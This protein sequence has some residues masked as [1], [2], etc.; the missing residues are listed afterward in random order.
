[1]P[2]AAMN[3]KQRL[4]EGGLRQRCHSPFPWR[5]LWLAAEDDHLALMVAADCVLQFALLVV[6]RQ[7]KFPQLQNILG[8]GSP[9]LEELCS[10]MKSCSLWDNGRVHV[11]R[12]KAQFADAD[13]ISIKGEHERSNN[14]LAK[15]SDHSEAV[16]SCLACKQII[17]TC[18]VVTLS[19]TFE[20]CYNPAGCLH[21]LNMQHHLW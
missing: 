18:S 11:F 9:F 16:V 15:A 5:A 7:A 2:P 19:Q 1:M 4:V 17:E 21:T 13:E 3:Q 12:C 8:E 6:A 20:K 14:A 10:A